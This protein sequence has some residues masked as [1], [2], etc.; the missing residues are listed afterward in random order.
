M[1]GYVV[2]THVAVAFVVFSADQANAEPEQSRTNAQPV[3]INRAVLTVGREVYTSVDAMA[4][5]MV[6]NLTRTQNEKPILIDTDW[7]KPTSLGFG[8]VG[9]PLAMIK[10][11]PEDV[12]QFFQIALIWVDVQKLNLFVQREQDIAQV[13][14]KFTSQRAELSKGVPVVLGDEVFNASESSRLKWID[15]VLRVRAFVRVR[16]SIERNKNLFSVGWYW[17]HEPSKR[18]AK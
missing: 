13:M 7:L 11:W 18:P 15:S 16:G 10:N 12:R 14:K 5:L 2:I 9:E 6:W 17:H 1:K 8:A 3:V 4:M